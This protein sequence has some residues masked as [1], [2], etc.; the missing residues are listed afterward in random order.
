MKCQSSIVWVLEDKRCIT[1]RTE[2]I[3]KW[4]ILWTIIHCEW[5]SIY[6]SYLCFTLF[7]FFLLLFHSSIPIFRKSFSNSAQKKMCGNVWKS[8]PILFLVSDTRQPIT[9]TNKILIKVASVQLDRYSIQHSIAFCK[10]E[11]PSL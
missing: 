3:G 2:S 9:I 10:I 5:I 8:F 7:I 11:I 6:S 1:N 4:R